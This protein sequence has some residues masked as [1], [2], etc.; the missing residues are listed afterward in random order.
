MTC[1]HP[2]SGRAGGIAQSDADFTWRFWQG[3]W[4]SFAAVSPYTDMGSVLTKQKPLCRI[5]LGRLKK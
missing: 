5:E 2:F 1:G 3:S 4:P